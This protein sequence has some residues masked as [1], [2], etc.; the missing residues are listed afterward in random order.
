MQRTVPNKAERRTSIPLH[1]HQPAGPVVVKVDLTVNVPGLLLVVQKSLGVAFPEVHVVA[2][3]SP[4][5][6]L[7]HRRGAR[8]VVPRV[9]V[10]V[11]VVAVVPVQD[12]HVTAAGL[13]LAHAAGFGHLVGH[14]GSRDSVGEGRLL[15]TCKYNSNRKNSLKK[16]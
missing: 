8:L 16:E 11:P 5:K 6:R 2:T 13:E 14:S 15:V 7:T 3:S 10:L 1:T 4:L 9:P 12:T